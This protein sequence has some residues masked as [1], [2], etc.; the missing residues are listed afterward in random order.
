MIAV[1]SLTFRVK[2]PTSPHVLGVADAVDAIYVEL[3]LETVTDGV[4]DERLPTAGNGEIV[5]E[6]ATCGGEDK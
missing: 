4:P 3:W 2:S 1:G 6:L 5:V